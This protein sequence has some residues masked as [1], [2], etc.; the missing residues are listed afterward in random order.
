MLTGTLSAGSGQSEKQIQCIHHS[1]D[2]QRIVPE[3]STGKCGKLVGQAPTAAD[4]SLGLKGRCA[5]LLF[6]LFE[7]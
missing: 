2:D 4:V 1:V 7:W 6:Q 3:V 5:I